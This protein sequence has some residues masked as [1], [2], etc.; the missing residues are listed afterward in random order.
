M[1]H[2][3]VPLCLYNNGLQHVLMNEKK[4][5]SENSLFGCMMDGMYDGC[6]GSGGVRTVCDG[7]W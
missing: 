5:R 3:E 7:V 6:G 4:S 2:A 1:S